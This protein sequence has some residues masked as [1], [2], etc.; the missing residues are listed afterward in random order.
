M[1]GRW[2]TTRPCRFT[3]GNFRRAGLHG[4][5]KSRAHREWNLLPSSPYRTAVL[6]SPC[7]A[8]PLSRPTSVSTVTGPNQVR[9]T[10][11]FIKQCQLEHVCAVLPAC[12]VPTEVRQKLLNICFLWCET[13][14]SPFNDVVE[15][16]TSQ[17]ELWTDRH[18]LGWR[19][20]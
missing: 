15:V 13:D 7:P 8:V 14:S 20:R 17:M 18:L 16:F 12:T 6:L 11:Q 4:C 19:G 2:P 10:S 3:L 9:K 5:G 1:G